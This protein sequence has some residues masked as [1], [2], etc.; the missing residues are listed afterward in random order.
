MELREYE[1]MAR[2]EAV[3]PWFIAT[4]GII[5]DCFKKAG[6]TPESRVLDVGCA[7]G[8][9]MKTLAGT[10]RFVGLDSSPVA[11]RLARELSG[12]E[13]V[14]ADA[15]RMPFDSASFD[16]VVACHILEHIDDHDAAVSEIHRVLKPGCPLIALVPCHQFMYNQHDRSLHHVRRY[17]RAEFLDLLRRNGFETEKVA[18]TNSLVFPATVMTRLISRI[19]P[20]GASTGRGS[21][22]THRLG[23]LLPLLNAVT[24]AERIL[25]RGA[26][27][28]FG[29]GLMVIARR[30]GA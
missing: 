15:T 18:W 23:P 26:W 10:A 17:S 7:T 19:G 8:G 6:V 5:R 16:A 9:T 14:M 2:D 24:G 27:Q 28:P 29:V 3:H 4:R 22:T 20:K 25:T 12:A 30:R 1:L 21:D 11:A 13:V